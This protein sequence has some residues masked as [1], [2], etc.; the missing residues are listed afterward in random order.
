MDR[1]Y[2][3]TK[4]SD[5]GGWIRLIREEMVARMEDGI[6]SARLE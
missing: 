1:L 3:E 2:L 4:E 5:R 6:A